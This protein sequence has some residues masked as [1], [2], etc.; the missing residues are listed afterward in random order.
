MTNQF[1][2]WRGAS[3]TPLHWAVSLN[4]LTQTTTYKRDADMRK[5]T[6]KK[7]RWKKKLCGND[8][9]YACT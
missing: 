3:W 1:I 4:S 9:Y 8:T 7:L 6:N 2:G 5:K